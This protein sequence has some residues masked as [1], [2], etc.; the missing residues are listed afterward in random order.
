MLFFHT[1]VYFAIIHAEEQGENK[2]VDLNFLKK[3]CLKYLFHSLRYL[4]YLS[5]NILSSQS[6]LRL[7]QVLF[8]NSIILLGMMHLK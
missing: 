1:L 3:M 2:E 7:Y 6:V 5:H 4:K 8:V